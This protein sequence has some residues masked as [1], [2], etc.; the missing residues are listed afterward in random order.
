MTGGHSMVLT[1]YDEF[2]VHTTPLPVSYIPSTDYNWDEGYYF[3]LLNPDEKIF[4]CTGFRVNPNTDMIGGYALFNRAG[5]QRTFRFSRC[6]RQDYQLRVGP[7]RVEV[8][9]PL[10][11]LRLVLDDNDSGIAFDF[12]W[13]GCSPAFLEEHHSAETRG[14]RT[15][16][17][18]RYSQPGTAKGRLEL[19][20]RPWDVSGS[21]W[22]AVRDHSWGLYVERPPFAAN[23]RWLPPKP[24]ST[25][26]RALR[27]WVVF[28]TGPWSGFY[29]L[30]EDAEGRQRKL[31]DVFG[32]PFGGRLCRG[33]SDEIIELKAGRH[34]IEFE[35]G[36]RM[37]RRAVVMLTDAQGREWRQELEPAAPPWVPQTMGY[38]PGSWKDGGT[39]HSY[40]GSETLATEWDEFDFSK[41]PF[42]YTPYGADG[43]DAPDSMQMGVSYKQ[44]IHGVEYLVRIRL[45]A[46]DGSVTAGAGQLEMFIN[47][48]YRPYGFE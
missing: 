1:P 29:H 11:T 24:P 28:K 39:F 36:T 31:D 30:H 32:T 25:A 2:P 22:V 18:S 21:G 38:T 15:T 42:T 7:F 5:I 3:G 47:G 48:P 26:A 35:P 20:E 10:R 41:Q 23:P 34:A 44:P 45:I 46:P 17:Q 40:H 13:E 14:R 19:A 16:D 9:E 33:W 6:W 8:L 37:L 12:L 4:F 43:A 27:F